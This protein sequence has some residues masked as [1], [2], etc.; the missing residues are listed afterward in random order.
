MSITQ[1]DLIEPQ[2]AQIYKTD[3][4]GVHYQL[5]YVD[6]QVV[7]LRCEESGR[8]EGNVHR[9]E[10][11]QDFV[12]QVD[13]GKVKLQPDS[14]L[15]MM[16]FEEIDWSEVDYIGEKTSENL[17]NAGFETTLDVRQAD[18]D[19]LLDVSGLGKAGLSGLRDFAQ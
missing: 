14:D 5:L 16:G 7:L 3:R 1:T 9:I 10:R 12:R 19:E 11:R 17:H 18:D 8:N 15:D 2:V 4:N 13:S 6:E